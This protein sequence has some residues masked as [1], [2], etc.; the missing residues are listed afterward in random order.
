MSRC[1]TLVCRMP[2]AVAGG[3]MPSAEDWSS[4]ATHNRNA[5]T[6]SG[7]SR[8]RARGNARRRSA[9]SRHSVA[10]CRCAPRPGR[11]ACGSGTTEPTDSE[12]TTTTRTRSDFAARFRQPTQVRTGGVRLIASQSTACPA[13]HEPPL[14]ARQD[15]CGRKPTPT[16]D[17]VPHLSECRCASPSS[18]P[19][20]E[21]SGP[22][23][24]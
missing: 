7:P 17:Q 14:H 13:V 12:G 11:L 20:A 21:R 4:A 23:Y 1:S 24:R 5:L 16:P 19:P 3:A 10:G 18:G 8:R 22:P 2:P 9:R 6:S 15:E